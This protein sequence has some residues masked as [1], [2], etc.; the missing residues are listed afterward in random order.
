MNNN[1]FPP[2]P[3]PAQTACGGTINN[4]DAWPSATYDGKM[5]YFCSQACLRVFQQYPDDFMAGGM[6]HPLDE[7]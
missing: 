3:E 5:I 4:T 6:E 7:D 1:P 2:S